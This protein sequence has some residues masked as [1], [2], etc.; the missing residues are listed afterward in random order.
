MF[1][2]AELVIGLR[3]P[4]G[5]RDQPLQDLARLR[6]G[7]PIDQATEVLPAHPTATG[8][9]SPLTA[10]RRDI[11]TGVWS[12][13]PCQAGGPRRK[14]EVAATAR[15]RNLRRSP[16]H[17][18][19][20]GPIPR[21]TDLAPE[22]GMDDP[23]N[24]SRPLASRAAADRKQ[25]APRQ[26]PPPSATARPR[27]LDQVRRACRLRHFSRRTEDAYAGWIRRFIAW[28]GMRHP[29]TLTE[30]DVAAFL[31]SLAVDR[32]VSASTQN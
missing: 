17:G 27:L 6:H 2:S 5:I 18:S 15:T 25:P 10:R 28:S 29:T 32:H 4:R 21:G 22:R 16:N 11:P 9:H 14:R 26:T 7:C 13:F 3:R 19:R 31:S 20:F 1:Q 24:P 12:R 23:R 30:T 8:R